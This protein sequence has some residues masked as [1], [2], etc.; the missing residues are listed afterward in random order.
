[1]TRANGKTQVYLTLPLI[2]LPGLSSNCSA[3]TTIICTLLEQV[4][5]L[6]APCFCVLETAGGHGSL[7]QL[8]SV[9]HVNRE[10]AAHMAISWKPKHCQ[11]KDSSGTLQPPP[12]SMIS[13]HEWLTALTHI[14]LFW[15]HPNSSPISLIMPVNYSC[16]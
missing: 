7:C 3:C 15:T 8:N 10:S 4:V 6:K 11:S 2:T 13:L 12:P 1:M 16:L 9:R 5:L 14:C